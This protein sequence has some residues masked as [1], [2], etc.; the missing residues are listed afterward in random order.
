M[1]AIDGVRVKMYHVQT[2]T[3]ISELNSIHAPSWMNFI[4]DS[5][6][7]SVVLTATEQAAFIC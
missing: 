5:G 1:C 4:A 7:S 2:D 6:A 3:L